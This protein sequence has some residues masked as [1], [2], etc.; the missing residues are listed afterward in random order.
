MLTRAQTAF[1]GSH[2]DLAAKLMAALEAG[3]LQG[4]GDG[5]EQCHKRDVPIPGDSAFIQVD[6]PGQPAG[7]YLK[8]VVNQSCTGCD[9]RS[10]VADL[11]T[12]FDAW[13]QTHPCP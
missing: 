3:A 9:C 5:R 13:R 1:L 6:R 10:A 2:C 12:L 4:G 11:R 8:L 7:T